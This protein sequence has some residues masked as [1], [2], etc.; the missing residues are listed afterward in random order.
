MVAVTGAGRGSGRRRLTAASRPDQTPTAPCSRS[1]P[2]RNRLSPRKMAACPV[3]SPPCRPPSSRPG[4]I[5]IGRVRRRLPLYGSGRASSPTPKKRSTYAKLAAVERRHTEMWAKLLADNGH[6]VPTAGRRRRSRPWSWRGWGGGSAR[7]TCCRCL[8]REEGR[9]VKGYMDLHADSSRRGRPRGL[10]DAGEGIGRARRDPGEP[11]AGAERRAVASDR[12]GR[13]P[14]QRGVRVQRR[15]D[16]Q[17]RPRGGRDR[18]RVWR[19]TS[20]WSPGVAG[21]IADALSMGS[22]GYLAA[23]SE[24]EVYAHEIAMEKEEI[25]L[26]PEVEAEELALVYEAKGVDPRTGAADGRRGDARP[27]ARAR[28]AGARGAE[29]RRGAQSR[30]CRRGGSPARRRRSARSSRSRP[31]LV[32]DGRA[33]GVD[34]VRASRWSRTSRSARRAACSPAAASSAAG[35]TCSWWGSASPRSATSSASWLAEAPARPPGS[36]GGPG[37]RRSSSSALPSTNFCAPRHRPARAPATSSSRRATRHRQA[38]RAPCRSPAPRSRLPRG[39]HAA[40]RRRARR[41]GRRTSRARAAPSSSSAMCGAYGA[42][43]S[44]SGSIAARC[45]GA[46]FPQRRSR[47]P[48]SP[49]SPCCSRGVSVSSVTLWIVWCSLRSTAAVSGASVR[50]RAPRR[51]SAHTLSRKRR[52]PMIPSSRKSPPSSNGPRNIRYMRNVSA[53]HCSMYSSGITTLPRDLRHLRAVLDDQAVGAELRE[54]LLEVDVPDVVQHH[55]D[56]AR[57]HQVQHGVLVAADVRVDRQPLLACSAGSNGT[58]SHSVRRVAQEVP[59]RVEEG[60]GDVGLAPRR[61]RRTAGRST[62]YHSRA[63]A[64]GEHAGVVGAEVLDRRAARPADPS[65]GTGTGAAARR[66]R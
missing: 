35:S 24:Q 30:R 62:R 65:P 46:F 43:S 9:E 6:P 49:R 53:P 17:L 23:K 41:L 44:T 60:V 8:L 21:M 40:R 48:S 28:G 33:G 31:F 56:E 14:A 38:R 26:M 52:T 2:S 50:L 55:R 3:S 10:A 58:S 59:G 11:S 1:R 66:S 19:R 12:I 5:T 54:R 64:S 22:S 37:R 34:G 61:A 39:G 25:R 36:A 18:R 63:R 27:A 16:G 20:C 32:L 47:T 7:A 42:S 4:C 45:A 29:D 57:V 15:A 51:T 13:V